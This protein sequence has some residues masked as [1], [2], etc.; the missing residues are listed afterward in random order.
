MRS[1]LLLL[2]ACGGSKQP[3]PTPAGPAAALVAPGAGS[4]DVVVATVNGRPVWGSCVTVQHS[5]DDCIGFELMAQAAEKRGLASDGDVELAARTAM[6]NRLVEDAYEHGMTKPSDF[7][8][9]WD[10]QVK[11]F[12]YRVD[13]PEVRASH[14]VRVQDQALAEQIAAEAGKQRGWMPSMLDDLAAQLAGGQKVDKADVS[15]KLPE[16][17]EEHYAHALFTVPE[18]G[19]TSPATHTKWGWDVVLYTDVLPARHPSQEEIVK[20]LLPPLKER[21]FSVWV[22][23]LEVAMNL[24]VEE[25]PKALEDLAE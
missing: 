19:R 20:E 23:Q 16:Q 8:D 17:L 18:I 22:H 10:K 21:Y 7:G 12:I 25:N 24:H 6:V 4:G 11:P 5:L 9:A 1:W 15:F 13:H 3:P 14:Y 2:A